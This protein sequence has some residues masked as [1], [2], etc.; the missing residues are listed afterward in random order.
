MARIALIMIKNEAVRIAVTLNIVIMV[1]IYDAGST[2]N[3]V[4]IITD[5]T[6]QM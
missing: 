5:I 3:T 2:D 6:Y 4:E 1:I